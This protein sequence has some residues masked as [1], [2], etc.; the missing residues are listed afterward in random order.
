MQHLISICGYCFLVGMFSKHNSWKDNE[1]VIVIFSQEILAVFR[2]DSYS[3]DRPAGGC[4]LLVFP[5]LMLLNCPP[6]MCP[7]LNPQL[8]KKWI[9]P[10]IIKTSFVNCSL[11]SAN[12]Y[13]FKYLNN[14]ETSKMTPLTPS[15]KLFTG[16][17]NASKPVSSFTAKTMRHIRHPPPQKL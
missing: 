5:L 7:T 9:L 4:R 14:G 8:H 17:P 11:N 1:I 6:N 3:M 15:V 12:Q 2:Y 16:G 13:T 10:I